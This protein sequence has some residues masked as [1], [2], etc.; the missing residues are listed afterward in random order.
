MEYILGHDFGSSGDKACIF[1]RD[2]H[3]LAE[4]YHT[5]ETIFTSDGGAFQRPEDWWRAFCLST[6][7]VIEKAEI[8]SADIAAVSFGAQGNALLPVDVNGEA[9]KKQATIWMDSRSVKEAEFIKT[10][11]SEDHYYEISGNAFEKSMCLSAKLLY[12]KRHE[13]D[14]I[15]RA[16]KIIGV[17]EYLIF[18]LTGKFGFTDFGDASGSCLFDIHKKMYSD[19]ILEMIGINKTILPVPLDCTEMV[20]RVRKNVSEKSGLKAGTAVILGTW[21]NFAC[22]TGA[23]V[24]KKGTCVSYLGTAGWIGVDSEEPL[25]TKKDKLNVVYVGS[26]EYHNSVHSHAACMSYDWVIENI[27]KRL[28]SVDKSIF[29]TAAVMAS[30]IPAGSDGVFF[31]PAMLCGNTFYQDA[32]LKCGFLGLRPEHHTAHLIRAAMEGVGFDLMLGI[33]CFE[34]RGALPKESVVI[35]G[36]A[37]NFLWIQML[38]DM[39][40]IPMIRPVNM[41][42]IGAWGAAMIAG[43]GCGIYSD[44]SKV[45][46]DLTVEKRFVPEKTNHAIYKRMLPKVRCIYETMMKLYKNLEDMSAE[47]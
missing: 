14:I 44:F 39:F 41:Q 10:Q 6:K 15:K 40:G 46:V 3:F 16:S 7:E 11:I 18:R 21:D 35:G 36:G 2:G 32:Y 19:E 9:L 31:T 25:G 29:E 33:E 26:N 24:R 47:Q 13:D 37:Q 12:M 8:N 42:H 20:G 43:V 28:S 1:D 34:K 45:S 23:G 30:E 5:Y 38:S 27:F 17:K 22:A 4:A